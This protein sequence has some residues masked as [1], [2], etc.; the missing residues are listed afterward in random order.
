MHETW[1][2]R[3]RRWVDAVL[4]VTARFGDDK[5]GRLAASLAYRTVFALA[6]LL[7]VAVA[8]A[9]FVYGSV[10][11]QV[12]LVADIEPVVGSELAS[13]VSDLL[14]Q[15]AESRSTTGII[16]V[17]LMSWTASSLFLEAQGSL[18]LVFGG[19]P[20]PKTGLLAWIVRRLLAL[21]AALSMGLVLLAVLLSGTL[22]RMIR[23]RVDW[24]EPLKLGVAWLA[25]VVGWLVVV[26]LFT[27]MFRLVPSRVVPWR[28]AA[29]G[30]ALTSV[31]FA[32]AAG[33]VGIYFDADRF[34][35]TGFAGGFVLILFSVYV[36]A[37]V[38]LFGAEIIDVHFLDEPLR[39][40]PE[41]KMMLSHGS[42]VVQAERPVTGIGWFAIGLAMGAYLVSRIR[43][44][45]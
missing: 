33:V 24:S 35:G 34:T 7:L 28:P 1:T 17:L 13:L 10:D 21:G 37:Q 2:K 14:G 30:G 27:L 11:A 8:V 19:N 45:K 3:P 39:E 15:A 42:G 5:G 38:V 41:S 6:P 40:I 32:I 43:S 29:I 4:A 23:S 25:P 22:W 20:H 12:R 36:L 9:G 18:D 16:G 26:G 44:D 31:G